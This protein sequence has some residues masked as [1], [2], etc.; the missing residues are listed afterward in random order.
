MATRPM[1]TKRL[2][3]T[4]S[5]AMV[6]IFGWQFLMFK[7][8]GPSRPTANAPTTAPVA[9]TGPTTQA[10]VGGIATPPVPGTQQAG[11]STTAASTQ[12][13]PSMSAAA[14]TPA[15]ST[16]APSVIT[17]GEGVEYAL[18]LNLTTMGAAIAD[19]TLKDFPSSDGKARYTFQKPYNPSDAST[20]SMA[21]RTV[22]VNE[23][24]VNV[25]GATWTVDEKTANSA[26]LS[27]EIQNLGQPLVRIVRTYT[28]K[29]KSDPSKGLEP[30]VSQSFVNLTK[31]PV[32]IRTVA[33]GPTMPPHESEQQGRGGDLQVIAG[34]NNDGEV[35]AYNHLAESFTEKQPSLELATSDKKQPI[36]WFGT[37]S[38]YFN[39]IY[40]PESL[41]PKNPSPKYIS[42]VKAEALN[43]SADAIDK[44]IRLTYE[45]DT[46]TV[47]ANQSVELPAYLF[48][49]PKQRSLLQ[50]NYYAAFPRSYN[51][52][53]VIASGMCGYCTI[54]ALINVLVLILG[55]FHS[56][57]RDWGLAIIALVLLVRGILH[58]ITK[59]SQVS[60]M[61]MGKMGPEVERLKKKYGDDK[62]ELNKAMMQVY[63]EQGFTPI[64]GCLPMFLQMPIWIALWSALQS[65][66]E[67][68]QA[69]F[70]YGLTW[71]HDLAKP[72]QLIK[73]AQPI[74]LMIF[75]WHLSAINLL[76]L[77]MI[78]VTYLNSKYMPQPPATTPEQEQ[79][80]KMM[81]W[82]TM[83]FPLM[84]YSMPSGLNLYYVTSMGLGII[85]SKIIRDHIKQ[86][87]L[88]EKE[89]KV[90]ID[91]PRSMK[92]KRD[93]EGGIG[94]KRKGPKDPPKGF[95]GKMMA[96]IQAKAE[97]VRKQAEKK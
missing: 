72:D 36:L 84:F 51:T 16:T 52:T 18:R 14:M 80:Q 44:D 37:A 59:R 56:I 41:D 95:F 97:Q 13:A 21:L 69:P 90:I 42:H 35:V 2:V 87:E 89:G 30:S 26:R 78:G 58:P 86:K 83:V 27:L 15:A 55:I 12:A 67:L 8:Y 20:Y 50:E 46:L 49:G 53:L 82:M 29:P 43:L 62:D 92:K 61:K 5:L 28:L 74:P 88:E 24:A 19:A 9:T 33:N 23:T 45:T 75:G 47:P 91:A 73:F 65:T 7:L 68:R 64:L 81:K 31:Q 93:E 3:L 66:F 85:E 22:T 54:P 63:K 70:L 1:E 10:D 17:L 79:Q 77:L 94:A 38:I 32:T 57:F 40:R 4:M 48:L 11:A 34:Y 71:I 76:P 6:I 60:M 39:S 96:D 25:A